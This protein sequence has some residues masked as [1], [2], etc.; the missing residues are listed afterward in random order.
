MHQNGNT[1]DVPNMV[2]NGNFIISR[3]KSVIIGKFIKRAHFL[4]S[5]FKEIVSST[6]RSTSDLWK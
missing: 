1:R 6:L 4:T 5:G 3:Q 2:E